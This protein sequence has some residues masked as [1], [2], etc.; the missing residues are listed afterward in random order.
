MAEKKEIRLSFRQAFAAGGVVVSV[1]GSAFAAGVKVESQAA[2]VAMLESDRKWQQTVA[3]KELDVIE[4][5]RKA[6]E[7]R[8]NCIY[9]RNR[10]E[11]VKRQ[12]EARDGVDFGDAEE[13]SGKGE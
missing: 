5:S 8:E 4:A 7:S 12:L 6:R 3:A 11:F 1:V 10:Y 13:N 9:Y 2:K